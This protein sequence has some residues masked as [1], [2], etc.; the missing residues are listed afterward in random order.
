MLGSGSG[1]ENRIGLSHSAGRQERRVLQLRVEVEP[2][3]QEMRVDR[4]EEHGQIVNS[5]D[6]SEMR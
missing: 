5:H 3:E 1:E 4:Q 2:S 6:W